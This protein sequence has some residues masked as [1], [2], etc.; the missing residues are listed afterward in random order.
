MLLFH[1]RFIGID[2]G[3]TYLDIADSKNKVTFRIKNSESNFKKILDK[4]PGD[5]AVCMEATGIYY[6]NVAKYLSNTSWRVYVV[7]PKIIKAYKES[8]L[9]RVKTDKVDSI[10]I[11]KFLS[12]RHE[13]L[14]RFVVKEN[15]LFVLTVLVNFME[16]LKKQRTQTKNR[17]H[18]VAFVKPGIFTE[19]DSLIDILNQQIKLVQ[20]KAIEHIKSHDSLK[21]Q[22]DALLTL[23]GF[24]EISA[25]NLIAASGGFDR[26]K[27]ARAYAAFC[28]LTPK[29]HE[30]GQLT[31]RPKISKLGS[32]RARSVLW[33]AA[34]TASKGDSKYGVFYRALK[35]RGKKPAVALVA[36]ANRLARAAWVVCVVDRSIKTDE[37][38]KS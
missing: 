6:V 23:P 9:S 19:F 15:D 26:F 37:S 8:L 4:F 18:A 27:S 28:G 25:M 33:L 14:N 7:N 10:H 12:E 1:V 13:E 31:K 17:F 22:F 38:A 21:V 16:S 35:V 20:F 3:K 29:F 34:L 32:P 36:V 11:S 30:S 24:G 5:N 2:V